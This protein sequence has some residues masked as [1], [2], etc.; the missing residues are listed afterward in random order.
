MSEDIYRQNKSLHTDRA[1]KP[2][3]SASKVSQL[4]TVSGFGKLNSKSR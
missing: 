1:E 3:G 4:L 2:A